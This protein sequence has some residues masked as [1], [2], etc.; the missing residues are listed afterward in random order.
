MLAILGGHQDP[1]SV[2]S[3]ERLGESAAR[4]TAEHSAYFQ[5]YASLLTDELRAVKDEYAKLWSMSVDDRVADGKAMWVGEVRRLDSGQG[6]KAYA[7]LAEGGRNDTEF[8]VGDGLL[9]SADAP[10]SGPTVLAG[11]EDVS[12]QGIVVTT[13]D[14]LRFRPSLVDLYTDER[15]T[16]ALFSGLFRALAEPNP[17]IDALLAGKAPAFL[18]DEAPAIGGKKGFGE[19]EDLNRDQRTALERSLQAED[20]LLVVGPPGSGKTMLIEHMVREHLAQGR[21]VLVCAGT[22]RALDE[23]MERLVKWDPDELLRLGGGSASAVL[24]EFTLGKL[25]AG[26]RPRSRGTDCRGETFATDAAESW[27]RR[28]IRCLAGATSRAWGSL[29]W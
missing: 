15:F 10:G 11:V 1:R 23:A 6:S 14:E 8:R 5:H 12:A 22:N 28:C 20:Y 21:R 18:T 13:Q 3:R 7:L 2:T 9:L 4:L 29:T 19:V 24:R 26:E 25:H 27:A 17:A 16:E